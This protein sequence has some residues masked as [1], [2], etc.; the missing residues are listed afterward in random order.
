[1]RK[2]MVCQVDRLVFCDRV[3]FFANV[4]IFKHFFDKIIVPMVPSFFPEE[5]LRSFYAN[6][7]TRELKEVENTLE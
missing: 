4:P 5:D 6:A 7:L 1:M 2:A 3:I